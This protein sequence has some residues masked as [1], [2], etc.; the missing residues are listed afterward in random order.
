M[1]RIL[2][3]ETATAVCSVVLVECGVEVQHFQSSE[4]NDHAARLTMFIQDIF[5][6][7]GISAT[8]LDAV[9]VSMG[10]GSY[11]GLRIGVS[12]AKGLC[13]AADKPLI[14]VSTLE[15]MAAGLKDRLIME[16]TY[17]EKALFCPMIDA[18]RMEV[19]SAVYNNELGIIR[20]IEAEVI[21][22]NSFKDLLDSNKIYFFGSGAPKTTAFLGQN[23]NSILIGDFIPSASHMIKIARQKYSAGLF[24]DVAYFE[25][26]Y[27]KDFIAG[28]PRVK[29]L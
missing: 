24:E 10:P 7:Q 20:S 1:A 29:G 25:P 8:D 18:R 15:A 6:F 4:G 12:V 21:D 28:K 2:L 9:A 3:I 22:E 11:T 26:F 13:Y 14:S 5:N 16:K 27:L 23:S 17:D 19:Y